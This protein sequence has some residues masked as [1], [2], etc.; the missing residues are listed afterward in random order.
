MDAHIAFSFCL[1]PIKVLVSIL[2]QP[3]ID[4]IWGTHY[5]DS[6]FHNGNE[7]KSFMSTD[8]SSYE[9]QIIFQKIGMSNS[10]IYLYS[11]LFTK[12]LLLLFVTSTQCT[13]LR[14]ADILTCTGLSP[15]SQGT[16]FLS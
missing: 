10:F 3:H 4:N 5:V 11:H 16:S 14:Y 1:L 12:L 7:I 2:Q 6:N 15:F 8:I 13:F 9:F